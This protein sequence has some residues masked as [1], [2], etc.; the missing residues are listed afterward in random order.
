[1][2]QTIAGPVVN[3]D[4]RL[5]CGPVLADDAGGDAS[6]RKVGKGTTFHKDEGT[7]ESGLAAYSSQLTT[8]TIYAGTGANACLAAEMVCCTSSSLCAALRKAASNCDGGR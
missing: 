2:N 1:M 7:D 6:S 5:N 8:T 4:G 3:H